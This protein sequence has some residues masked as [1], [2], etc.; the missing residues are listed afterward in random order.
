MLEVTLAEKQQAASSL[1]KHAMRLLTRRGA[2]G[3]MEG[4]CFQLSPE[5]V[6]VFDEIVKS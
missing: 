3:G 2:L 4:F 1:V 5:A 6:F